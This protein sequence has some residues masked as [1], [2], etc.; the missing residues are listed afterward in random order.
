MNKIG[1][2]RLKRLTGAEKQAEQERLEHLIG[3]KQGTIIPVDKSRVFS[4]TSVP[5]IPD[6]YRDAWFACQDC[7]E[8]ELWTAKQQKRWYE[9]QGGEIEAIAI[10]CRACRLK[11]KSRRESARSVHL[12]GLEQKRIKK[13][14]T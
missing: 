14:P 5:E 4:R 7:G 12:D 13:G 8:R 9:E 3:L 10:H 1:L 2:K 11:A 6:Y